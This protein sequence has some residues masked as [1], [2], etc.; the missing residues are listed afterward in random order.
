MNMRVAPVLAQFKEGIY[1]AVVEK[2][3]FQQGVYGDYIRWSFMVATPKGE[4]ITVT[5][6]TSRT[7]TPHPKCKFYHWAS[8]VRGKPFAVGEVLETDALKNLKCR[9]YLVV[10]ELET[11]GSVNQVEWVLPCEEPVTKGTRW[12]TIETRLRTTKSPFGEG[13]PCGCTRPRSVL[14]VWQHL[15][16]FVGED[17]PERLEDHRVGYLA[18][19]L[20]DDSRFEWYLSGCPSLQSA[21]SG[22]SGCTAEW[23]IGNPG[24]RT[25]LTGNAGRTSCCICQRHPGPGLHQSLPQ[26]GHE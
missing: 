7:F 19:E 1:D 5:G 4:A 24:T 10:R 3:E 2:L 6:L 15:Q 21:A 23:Y 8:T 9:V 26:T 22:A 20:A 14:R 25:L 17:P 11:G 18:L 16:S 12:M 13:D